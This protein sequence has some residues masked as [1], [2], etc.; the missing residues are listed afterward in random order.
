MLSV[1]VRGGKEVKK[2]G[3]KINTDRWIDRE[4]NR[5]KER[6]KKKGLETGR[7]ERR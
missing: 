4:I 3:R 2:K 5:P 6:K 7:H 1:S